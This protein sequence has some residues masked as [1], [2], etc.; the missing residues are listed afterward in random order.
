M[1]RL[2]AA[3]AASLG[4]GAG[5]HDR[6]DR[7]VPSGLVEGVDQLL[8]GLAAKRIIL[9]RPVDGDPGR[10]ASD[11]IG[12]VAVLHLA[13]PYP[14]IVRPPETLITWPV[15]KLASSLERK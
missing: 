15:M 8:A 9:V 14:F 12:D 10:G 13:L 11:V 3:G 1:C 4:S 2:V 6:R 5:Q 7:L